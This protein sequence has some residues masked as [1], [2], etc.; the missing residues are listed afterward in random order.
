MTEFQSKLCIVCRI[1]LEQAF[2][3][4]RIGHSDKVPHHQTKDSLVDSVLPRN[5]HLCRLIVYFLRLHWVPRD[6]KQGLEEELTSGEAD[7]ALTEDDFR[8]SEFEYATFPKDR[9]NIRLFMRGL[10]E[11]VGLTMQ[12]SEF[13]E[14][15]G[16]EGRFLEF[17]CA[18]FV[19]IDAAKPSFWIFSMEGIFPTTLKQRTCLSNIVLSSI[20]RLSQH[21]QVR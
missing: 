2:G 9:L 4:L 12:I 3:S 1:A 14:I 19:K 15:L 5:C 17:D 11:D 21:P 18:S 20:L 7:S 8:T 6:P 10:P 13:G 16:K